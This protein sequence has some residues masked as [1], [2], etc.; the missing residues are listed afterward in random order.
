MARLTRSRPGCIITADLILGL[1][2]H[3]QGGLKGIPPAARK[4]AVLTQRGDAAPHPDARR[5]S[6]ELVTRGFD[7]AVVIAPRSDRPV[8][9]THRRE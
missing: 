7:Q 8:L 6:A 2:T 1:L 4:V 5:I 9:L 3:A